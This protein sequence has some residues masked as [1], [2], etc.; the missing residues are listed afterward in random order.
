MFRRTAADTNADP[1]S[2]GD[3]HSDA[4]ADGNAYTD[5]DS[6]ADRYAFSDADAYPARR[7]VYADIDCHGKH[8]GV[9]FDHGR[10]GKCNGGYRNEFVPRASGTHR[11]FRNQ[12]ER[13]DPGVP[14]WDIRSGD[15]NVHKARR[16][17][18]GRLYAEGFFTC[19]FGAYPSSMFGRGGDCS[20]ACAGPVDMVPGTYGNV[21]KNT[22]FC[23]KTGGD[24]DK[25]LRFAFRARLSGLPGFSSGPGFVF[26]GRIR[27]IS[28]DLLNVSCSRLTLPK[29]EI[30]VD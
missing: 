1:D 20:R 13:D 3:A 30:N 27:S 6:D 7:N 12:R 10:S 23:I 22:R 18:A 11:H 17:T 4:D 29:S 19:K 24:L 21:R 5:G 8:R 16:V 15:G 28:F 2:D 25:R 14:V 26:K 9:R